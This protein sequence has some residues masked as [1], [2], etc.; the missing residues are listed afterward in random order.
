MQQWTVPS[1][2]EKVGDFSLVT[3]AYWPTDPSTGQPFAGGVIPACG[4][5]LTTD[6]ATANGL[7]LAALYPS[8]NG[9]TVGT[10]TGGSFNFL[11]P[12][13]I[14][15]HEHL[16]TVDY[17]KSAKNQIS[18]YL[19]HNYYTFLGN[20][21]NLIS[22]D[23]FVPGITSGLTWTN[24]INANTVNTLTGSFSRNII[25]ETKVIVRIRYCM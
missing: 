13:P 22:Y 2:Q 12:N 7:A 3:Q 15:T 23:R 21:T 25:T 17:I 16:V 5:S 10:S 19:V 18:G 20:A 1:D 14:N 24:I 9:P 4:G 11:A 8:A 6:C